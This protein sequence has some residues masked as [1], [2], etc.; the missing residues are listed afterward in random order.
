MWR[1]RAREK[2]RMRKDLRLGLPHSLPMRKRQPL[3]DR[4]TLGFTLKYVH[5]IIR[6]GGGHSRS[7]ALFPEWLPEHV[8]CVR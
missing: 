3:R 6:G 5:P 8:N 7:M 1:I 2:V 4:D